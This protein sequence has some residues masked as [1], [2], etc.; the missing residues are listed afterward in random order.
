MALI[1][2]VTSG[3]V[4]A[5]NIVVNS[6]FEFPALPASPANN[7]PQWTSNS[8]NASTSAD[9]WVFQSIPG[10]VSDAGAGIEV[11]RG[12][13]GGSGPHSGAQKVELDSDP[14]RGG[15]TGRSTNS[16]VYQD[17]PTHPHCVYELRF[18][19]RPRTTTPG[20]N[21]IEV[22]WD[23]V[24]VATAD[25]SDPAGGW[26]EIVVSELPAAFPW[27]ELRFTATG[28]V[29]Q[30]GGQIDDVSVVPLD[31]T[32][33]V[34]ACTTD[35]MTLWPPNHT[36]RKVGVCIAVSD[37][38]TEPEDLLLNCTVSSNEPDDAT[39]DG[40]TAGDVDGADGFTKPVN[41]SGDLAYD[42]DLGCYVG[43]ILLRAERDGAKS[44][45]IYSIVCDVLD[46]AGNEA[47]AGCTVVVPHDKRN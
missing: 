22:H 37:N 28:T 2:A 6:S 8:S 33:P 5:Q 29:N 21:T 13:V 42:A 3:K 19:Y 31:D 41:I 32:P 27:T 15:L 44:G 1:I 34:L 9:W 14:T 16:S 43:F 4:F 38:C 7:P 30:F 45:R 24:L 25:A 10:W 23:G 11:Q 47:T 20:D 12:N 36:L 39:G 46:S 26:R 17:L 35:V 18:W 40:K